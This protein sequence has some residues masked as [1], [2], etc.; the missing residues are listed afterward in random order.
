MWVH[1]LFQLGKSQFAS[2]SL[3]HR[4]SLP[5][6]NFNLGLAFGQQVGLF[7]MVSH[8]ILVSLFGTVSL[9][10]WHSAWP[11]QVSTQSCKDLQPSGGLGSLEMHILPSHLRVRHGRATYFASSWQLFLLDS[12]IAENQTSHGHQRR[13]RPCPVISKE[14]ALPAKTE[15][16]L[17]KFITGPTISSVTF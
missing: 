1:G 2:E 14:A 5:V 8:L 13:H 4:T 17:T 16:N 6:L 11:H 9:Q 3:C 15:Y 12:R 10:T 7:R